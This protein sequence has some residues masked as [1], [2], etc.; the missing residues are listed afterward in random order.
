[1]GEKRSQSHTSQ[2][3]ISMLRKKPKNADGVINLS[4][5]QLVLI[6]MRGLTKKEDVLCATN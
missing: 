3:K 1:M 5:A 4:P 2:C 6:N